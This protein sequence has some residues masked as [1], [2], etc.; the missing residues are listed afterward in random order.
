MMGFK[1]KEKSLLNQAKPLHRA[2]PGVSP[3]DAPACRRGT[4][5]TAGRGLGARP[6]P[7]SSAAPRP[8]PTPSA[9]PRPQPQQCLQF[10]APQT[11]RAAQSQRPNTSRSSASGHS[12]LAGPQT[13]FLIKAP[14]CGQ[15]H[16]CSSQPVQNSEDTQLCALHSGRLKPGTE[17]LY[18]GG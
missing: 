13:C 18:Q 6:A 4:E 5:D 16:R 7:R 2:P 8:I 14:W 10:P 9:Q 12:V 1:D 3:A 17:S 15:L 11:L